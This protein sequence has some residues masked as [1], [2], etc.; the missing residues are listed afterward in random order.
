LS[1]LVHVSR[2]YSP[3]NAFV[4]FNEQGRPVLLMPV[5]GTVT[6]PGLVIYRFAVG[7]FYANVERLV[8]EVSGLVSG[9][10]PP[11]WLVLDADAMDDVDYTGAETLLEIADELRRR[12]I[13][14]AVA[15]AN[16]HVRRVLDR[17]GLIDKI[18]AEHWFDTAGEALDAFAA[19]GSEP[20]LGGD[21]A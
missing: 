18:G 15:G 4:S 16:D 3:H 12:G 2:H 9:P 13:V 5:P 11:R 17:F 7:I 19:R 10:D 14:F 8:D 1:L 20:G 6:E 21:P